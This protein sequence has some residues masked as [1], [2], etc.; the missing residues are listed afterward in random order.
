MRILHTSDWHIGRSFHG[1]GMLPVQQRALEQ[2]AEIVVQH[3]IA[4]V[5][6]SGD[7]YDRALPAADAVRTL[8]AGLATLRETGAELVLT[9][10]NHDSSI[11]LGFGRELMRASGV[12]FRTQIA[13]I[14]HPVVLEDPDGGTVA[15]WG[16]PYLDPGTSAGHWGVEAQHTAVIQAAVNDIR[17][18][19]ESQQH[20][21]RDQAAHVVMAHLFAAGGTGSDSERDI[22][23]HHDE[24][25]VGTL[26]Q[27]PASIFEGFD[28]AA[29][30]HLHG[31]QTISP[32]VR[33]S[34]SPVA[35]SFSEADHTKG[36][37]VITTGQNRVTDI[38]PVD[39]SAG[40]KLARLTGE[41][42]DLLDNPEHTWAEDAWCQIT[43]TDEQRPPRA[44]QRLK[45]RFPELLNFILAPSGNP[46]TRQLTYAKRL[47]SATTDLDVV[48]DFI[49]HV[50][51][52]PASQAE[53]HW[54]SQALEQVGREGRDANLR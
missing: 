9:S 32:A 52:R 48:T 14:T 34:G 35:Y 6:V 42:D 5:V 24:T 17:Q 3:G 44:Y 30:G 40:K 41:I 47:A 4:A 38:Q 27:V 2:L 23:A 7:I 29:L 26:G 53:K 19:Q 11:R 15:I 25:T 28:Y 33:Y 50:R 12:H 20:L 45:Q 51:G 31:R 21:G 54:I 8:D 18:A 39:L 49:D 22:G 1:T 37:W 10:G 43:V 13:D 46:P 16:I 36:A